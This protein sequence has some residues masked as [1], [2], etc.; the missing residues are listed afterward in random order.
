MDI[1][2]FNTVKACE[3]GKWVNIVNLDGDKTDIRIKVIGVDSKRFKEESQKLAKYF[4]RTKND[5][6]RDYD[7]IEMKTISMAVAITVD[8]ENVEEDG[9]KVP[10]TKENVTRIYSY[11]PAIIE[12]ITKVAKD[13]HNFLSTKQKD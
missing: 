3:E 12:Q 8:W 5:K 10:F 2:T 4:E 7:E 13:R 9:K 11:A 1:S 6:V